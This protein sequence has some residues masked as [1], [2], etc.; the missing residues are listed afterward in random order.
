MTK[1]LNKWFLTTLLFFLMAISV[2]QCADKESSKEADQSNSVPRRGGT[3]NF[4][5]EQ[6][7]I[8]DP[9]SVEDIYSASVTNQIFEG[10]VE[11]DVNS[12][13]MPGIAESWVISDDRLE[14]RFKIRESVKF[15][16]GKRV[17]S[18]DVIYSLQRLI[19]SDTP[20]SL[21]AYNFLKKIKGAVEYHERKSGKITG[22]NAPDE[23]TIV[24]T[25]SEPYPIF[26]M[27]LAMDQVKIIPKDNIIYKDRSGN[28]RN[29]IGTGAFKVGENDKNGN[30]ELYANA[31]YYRGKPYLDKISYW[32]DNDLDEE[33]SLDMFLK[34]E[35]H[36]VSIYP[37]SSTQSKLGSNYTLLT[38]P[39][40]S[41]E[42]I[43]FN[44]LSTPLN[45]VEVRMGLLIG[46]TAGIHGI[47]WQGLDIA[48]EGIVPPGMIGYAPRTRP[49][50]KVTIEELAAEF[51]KKV[52]K[53]DMTLN[54]WS[55]DTMGTAKMAM[56]LKEFNTELAVHETS[57]E[58]LNEKI[59]NG[60]AD[61][62]SISWVADTPDA[63]SFIRSLFHSKS[64]SNNFHYSNKDVD[65]LIE[66][67]EKE[68]NDN[69]RSKIIREIEDIILSEVPL[70]PIA[71]Y[72]SAYAL[73]PNVRGLQLS[74]MDISSVKLRDVWLS[75]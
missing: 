42:Y 55:T 11:F 5:L 27:V 18:Y 32:A 56:I 58:N 66:E 8:L 12:R 17:N 37:D 72:V 20:G 51:R 16:N 53:S 22:L 14:Y 36:M 63:S 34:G 6:R 10:L 75:D 9:H 7:V 25:L 50:P 59:V 23:N 31:E 15:H 54:F 24:I 43:G 61:L 71:N 69:L 60:E 47:V 46:L 26:L 39:E 19:A 57:W 3:F 45:Y 21:A 73:Q 41:M 68:L 1:Y 29:L 67:S 28:W 48:A 62:W 49:D 52:T 40:L 13:P 44:L 74:Q 2:S 35:R 70:I 4:S 65:R 38:R 64:M 30:L 33:E